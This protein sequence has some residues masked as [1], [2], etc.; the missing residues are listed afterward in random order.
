MWNHKKKLEASWLGASV[1]IVVN[2][3]IFDDSDLDTGMAKRYVAFMDKLHG[4]IQEFEADM[5]TIYPWPEDGEDD[6]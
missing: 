5:Q 1:E 3:E 2:A 4:Q 6:E